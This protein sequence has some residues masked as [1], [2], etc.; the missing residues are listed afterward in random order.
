[1]KSKYL[2]ILEEKMQDFIE[3]ICEDFNME[4]DGYWHD[5]LTNQMATA[6]AMVLDS[7]FDGQEYLKREEE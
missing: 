7:A 3:E 1:M 4:H 6:A 2:S 5:N